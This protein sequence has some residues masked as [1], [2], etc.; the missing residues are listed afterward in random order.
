MSPTATSGNFDHTRGDVEDQGEDTNARGADVFADAREGPRPNVLGLPDDLHFDQ[1][2]RENM[3]L[4]ANQTASKRACGDEDATRH[5]KPH[6]VGHQHGNSPPTPKK[7]KI[8][9]VRCPNFKGNE[10]YPGFGAGF[11]NFIHEF[12]HAVRTEGLVNG[13]TWTDEFK[14]SIII[15]FLEGNA[16]RHYHKKNAEWRQ[17]HEGEDMPYSEVKRALRIEFGCKLSQLELSTK[18]KCFKREGDSWHDYLEYLNFIES[19][20][21]GDQT[22]LVMEV[23]GNNACPEL[24]PT[25]LPSISD[26]ATDYVEETDRMKR[27]LSKLKGDGRKYRKSGVQRKN[28]QGGGNKQHGYRN[29]DRNNRSNDHNTGRSHGNNGEN[30]GKPKPQ[31]NNGQAFGATGNRGEIGC[32]PGHKIFSCPVVEQAKRMASSGNAHLATATEASDSDDEAYI[33]MAAR[34]AKPAEHDGSWTV[35]SGATHHLCNDRDQLFAL[36]PAYLSVRV[37]NGNTIYYSGYRARQCGRHC[38]S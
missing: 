28:R 3:E 24:A 7:P 4:H 22:K 1:S 16:S 8:K 38:D 21:E 20:M 10:V 5:Q 26:E 18:M 31:Q 17:R 6:D 34:D 33:W 12:E 37:A 2:E 25:L 9:D 29:H 30:S 11:E 36:E 13:S 23:F 27:L 32:H 19:L 35:D 14:A 15:N